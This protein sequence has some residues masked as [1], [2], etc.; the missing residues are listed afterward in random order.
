MRQHILCEARNWTYLQRKS[1]APIPNVTVNNMWLYR[2]NARIFLT[3][4]LSRGKKADNWKA[5]DGSGDVLTNGFQLNFHV[6]KKKTE[7]T[8]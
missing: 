3:I 6:E 5:R 7:E 8:R 4:H 1:G 2:K